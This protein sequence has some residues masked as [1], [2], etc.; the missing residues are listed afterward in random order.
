MPSRMLQTNYTPYSF[1][2]PS[3]FPI[4]IEKSTTTGKWSLGSVEEGR[5]RVF[6]DNSLTF[7]TLRVSGLY[8]RMRW[9]NGGKE[10]TIEG[11]KREEN[12]IKS[13]VSVHVPWPNVWVGSTP[14]REWTWLMGKKWQGGGRGWRRGRDRGEGEDEKE[15][16]FK[17]GKREKAP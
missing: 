6:V 12:Q 17:K 2:L 11:Q 4:F 13:I 15:R 5:R 16:K 8:L 10:E 3:S 9:R 14:E 1:S 7:F